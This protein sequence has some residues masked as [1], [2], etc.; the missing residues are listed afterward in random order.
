MVMIFLYNFLGAL[1]SVLD[2]LSSSGNELFSV[3][4]DLE[5][6]LKSLI[7]TVQIYTLKFKVIH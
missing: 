6:P 3:F 5:I 1:L 7:S 2:R 4:F